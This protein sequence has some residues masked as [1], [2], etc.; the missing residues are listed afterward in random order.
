VRVWDATTGHSLHTLEGHEGRIFGV[1]FS[2]EGR[3]LASAGRDVKLWD[4]ATGQEVLTLKQNEPAF[5][6]V[7]SPDGRRLAAA[8]YDGTVKVWDATELTADRLIECE[9]RGL[10]QWLFAKPL[11]PDEVANAVRQDPTITEAVRQQALDWVEPC[12][13]NQVHAEASCLVPSL[14][15]KGLLRSEV[16]AALAA[17]AHLSQALRKEALTLADSFP[18]NAPAL[19]QACWEVLRRP[20]AAAAAYERALRQAEAAFN[21]QRDNPYYLNKVGA[22]QYRTGRYREA[23]ETLQK[24]ELLNKKYFKQPLPVALAFEAMAQHQLGQKEQAEATLARLRDLMQQPDQAIKPDAQ[25]LWREAEELL[26]TRPANA[27]ADKAGLA[28]M[29]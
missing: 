5:G 10:V 6:V 11:G 26:K 28:L 20:G 8:G 23:L 17:D 13:R 14:F 29:K 3:R 15:A 19:N 22:A 1:A 16:H 18:E 9:A 12:W 7:F 27:D 25:A 24:A 4:A 2:P 21:L